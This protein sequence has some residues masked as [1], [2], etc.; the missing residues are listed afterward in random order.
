MVLAVNVFAAIPGGLLGGAPRNCIVSA[1]KASSCPPRRRG[2]QLGWGYP[3]FINECIR[4]VRPDVAHDRIGTVTSS[5]FSQQ[6]TRNGRLFRSRNQLIVRC[7]ASLRWRHEFGASWFRPGGLTCDWWGC[8][9]ATNVDIH[10][11]RVPVFLFRL[12]RCRWTCQKLTQQYCK[13]ILRA[14]A[15]AT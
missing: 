12:L 7:R 11:S 2:V 5:L 1:C 13:R 4:L 6:Q 15:I 8:A 9:A 3:C 10:S 14:F